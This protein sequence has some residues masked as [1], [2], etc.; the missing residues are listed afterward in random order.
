MKLLSGYA[1]PGNVRELENTVEYAVNMAPGDEILV[2][3]LP[4]RIQK[5][6]AAQSGGTSLDS[7]QA[8]GLSDLSNF[9][10]EGRTLKAQTDAIHREIIASCLAKTGETLEGKRKAADLLGISESTLYR[11]LRELGM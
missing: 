8:L 4:P 3:N 9:A 2:T 5:A 1:W 7:I 6:L 10:A 11:R